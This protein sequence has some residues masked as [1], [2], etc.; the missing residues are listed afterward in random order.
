MLHRLLPIFSCSSPEQQPLLQH[1]KPSSGFLHM[2]FWT[3]SAACISCL[4]GFLFGFDLGVVGGLLIAPSFQSYFGIDPTDKVGEASINGN[5]VAFLQV[6]C[7]VGALLATITADRIGRKYSI[8]LSAVI[9]TIGG[10]LQ[11]V[12]YHLTLF[13]CGRLIAGLGV[14]AMSMLVPIYVAEIAP[15]NQRGF[16][17]GVWMFFIAT[18]LASSYWT[19]Y[20]VKRLVHPY[21]DQLWR[22]PLIVQTIP[23]V[24]MMVGM[25][26]LF[27]TPRWLCVHG[28]LDE[29]RL[30]LGKIRGL[31]PHDPK[32]TEEIEYLEMSLAHES[33]TAA[34]WTEIFS[35]KNR[36]RLIIGCTIQIFQQMTGTNVVN[37]YSPIIFRSIGLSSGETELLATGVYGLIKMASVLLGYSIL[38]DRFGRRPLLVWG[39][40]GMGGCLLVVA[41]CVASQSPVTNAG[42]SAY[43]GIASMFVFA[44]LFSLSWGPVPWLYC[45]EIFPMSIRA[46]SASLTTAINW[47][48]NA[49]IGKISPLLLAYS[50]VGTYILFGT[51]CILMSLT[52]H[53]ILL[54]TKG[55]SLEEMD[56]LFHTKPHRKSASLA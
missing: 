3:A 8:L 33:K 27:E 36:K 19:N 53:F 55:R 26:F 31:S 11:V 54:E 46:K 10:V 6:G 47:S 28:T 48:L 20:A 41:G 16:L 37:Y 38:V 9:F 15:Q 14:G 45:S 12:G 25:L 18:G 51:C 13:Y 22:I 7:L 32:I 42:G 17:S 4:G 21:D 56:A 29:T 35:E 52:C 40:I 44:I 23:G 34:T 24:I 2:P 39:G 5:I 49:V 43:M 30:V 50:T 1:N